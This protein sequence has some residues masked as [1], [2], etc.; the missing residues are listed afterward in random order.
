MPIDPDRY[1]L[2]WTEISYYIRFVRAKGRC[3]GSPVYPNCEAEH[4]KPH[5]ETGSTVYLT[6]AHL[7]IPKPD[8]SL[9]DPSDKM[10]NRPE[11]LRALCQRCHLTLDVEERLTAI[12]KFKRQQQIKAGQLEFAF[13]TQL[14]ENDLNKKGKKK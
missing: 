14:K 1:P 9:G 6:C 13:M 12:A 3:E 7:G 10:D 5:P 2:D 8:G 4:G 11:N